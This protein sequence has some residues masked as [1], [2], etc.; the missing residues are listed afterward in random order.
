MQ[1]N[2]SESHAQGASAL[3]GA[4]GYSTENDGLQLAFYDLASGKKTAA[5]T[6]EAPIKPKQILADR[7][8]GCVW[9]LT[10]DNKL[11]RWNPDLSAIEQEQVYSGPVYSSSSPDEE[12]LKALQERVDAINRDYG[13]TVRIWQAAVKSNNGYDLEPEYQTSAIRKALEKN[14]LSLN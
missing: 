2:V 1:L 14:H 13:V 9:I 6:I 5:V 11:L 4:V 12:G 7:W 8:T 3:G 10:E